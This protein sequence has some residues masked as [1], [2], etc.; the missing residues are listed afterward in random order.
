MTT[1]HAAL[2]EQSPLQPTPQRPGPAP[3]AGRFLALLWDYR[4]TL[5]L[6][7]GIG[8]LLG[9]LIA[10]L[11]PVTY[12]SS[13]TL[14]FPVA[15]SSR[16]ALLGSSSAGDLP[17]LPLLE[18]DLLVPQPG[19]STPTATVIIQSNHVREQIINKLQLGQAWKK[20]PR[21]TRAY[22][23]RHLICT[24][25]KNG[26]L[27]IGFQDTER[28]RAYEIA[29]ALV[30]ELNAAITD[31]GIDSAARNLKFLNQRTDQAYRKLLQVQNRLQVYQQQSRL[32]DTG[33]QVKS[34][35]DQYLHA[36]NDLA[37]AQIQAQVAE[38]Q[39]QTMTRKLKTMIAGRTDPS[40][41]TT[42]PLNLLAQKLQDLQFKFGDL[43]SRFTAD[44]PDVKLTQQQIGIVHEQIKREMTRQF[45]LVDASSSPALLD[46][47]VRGV[48][49]R[50]TSA[51]YAR[52]VHKLRQELDRLPRELSIDT[53]LKAQ[54]ETATTT[55]KLYSEELEKARIIAAS[56]GSVYSMA[57]PVVPAEDNDPTG[58]S[59]IV[60]LML[61]FGVGIALLFPYAR[62]RRELDSVPSATEA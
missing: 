22:F 32:I 33:G 9:L 48:E 46:V 56:R 30:D 53:R 55:Y 14:V 52:L 8:L 41:N 5:L 36:Q 31:L 57:D 47:A 29:L 18:G 37:T 27:T 43:R 19:S 26:E 35:S 21:A 7:A 34:L 49:A 2:D 50:A 4:R 6:G 39:L 61:L 54:L 24:T 28:G 62:W 60:V 12:T 59:T 20:S 45:V 42:S 11:K 51:G 13:A 23:T 10:L 1:T 15:G 17:S 3:S 38:Q 58:R 25:G 40:S 44:Y 16:A